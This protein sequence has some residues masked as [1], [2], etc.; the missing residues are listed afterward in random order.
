MNGWM[1]GWMVGWLAGWQLGAP[2]FS[3]SFFH[4]PC[5]LSSS[6]PNDDDDVLEFRL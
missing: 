3:F 6:S 1:D 2:D 5:R 4:I